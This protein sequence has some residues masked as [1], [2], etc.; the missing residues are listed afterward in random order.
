M[1]VRF[2]VDAPLAG[3]RVDQAVAAR[4]PELSRA[5]VR[6]LI[7]QGAI[8]V[9]D[10]RV[11]PSHRVHE[12]DEIA[13]EVPAPRALEAEPE[14]IPLVIVHEDSHLIV[15]DKPAGLVVH[16]AAGHASGTLVNALLFHC[17]DLS[18]VGGVLRPGIVHRLDKD[19][20]GLLVCAKSDPAHRA[21]AAQFKAHT[22]EREYLALVRGRPKAESGSVDAAIGRHPTDRKKFTTRAPRGRQA[23]THWRVER[24]FRDVTLLSV[25]LETGRTH[26]IRVHLASVGLPVAGDPVYGG[27]RAAARALGLARQALHAARLGFEHPVSAE[28]LTFT[29]PLPPDLARVLARLPQ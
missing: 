25:R 4:R 14:D 9:G 15:V 5:Q 24:R 13:V 19:T 12:G 26:Q 18:G 11:K 2:R 7:D 28:R 20:S 21:L 1:S 16:P 29:S 3:Q 10:T 17:R 22:I 27:G 23:R 8:R 6:R